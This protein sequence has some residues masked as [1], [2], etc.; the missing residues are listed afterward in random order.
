MEGGTCE[1]EDFAQLVDEVAAVAVG[2]EGGVVDEEDE[3]WGCC[4][5]LCEVVDTEAF[6]LDGRGVAILE[7]FFHKA[8]ELSCGDS[9]LAC[10]GY[11]VDEGE[12]FF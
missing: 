1:V 2:E 10:C 11:G 3:A 7:G 8:V 4:G 6:A 9:L 12:D 5:G